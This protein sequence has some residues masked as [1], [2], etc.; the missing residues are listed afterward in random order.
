MDAA[1]ALDGYKAMNADELRTL[2]TKHGQCLTCGRQLFKI[3]RYGAF[4]KKK[5][6]TLEGMVDNGRCLQCDRRPGDAVAAPT[7]QM[8]MLTLSRDAKSV[9]GQGQ[10]KFVQMPSSGN[11]SQKPQP[12]PKS[13]PDEATDSVGTKWM[14]AT[15][16]IQIANQIKR[17]S[18]QMKRFDDD[19]TH[20]EE[21][22]KKSETDSNENVAVA[23]T[24][25]VAA[26]NEP[27][28]LP[29]SPHPQNQPK[30]ER[31]STM[32]QMQSFLWSFETQL[33]V[34]TMLDLHENPTIQIEACKVL[35]DKVRD[36]LDGFI[37]SGATLYV[38]DSIEEHF[39]NE[40][41]IMSAFSLMSFVC[42][43]SDVIRDTFLENDGL[44]M[45][46]NIFVNYPRNEDVLQEGTK[47]LTVLCNDSNRSDL[48]ANYGLL[49]DLIKIS[50]D[51]KYATD[52]R[53]LVSKALS[54]I[55]SHS[56][57]ARAEISLMST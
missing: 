7:K 40:E 12:I 2:R 13:L 17:G 39:S 8:S 44:V 52:T 55:S 34:E 42:Q 45:I 16:K 47:L 56:E 30:A 53:A 10:D 50:K 19:Q 54:V 51:Q 27:S 1:G 43:K 20:H 25:A 29:E 28:E 32:E 57:I 18:D 24:V 3:A 6:I 49:P 46:N 14:K 9:S 37:S 15:T 22:K 21:S 33:V 23:A 48:V 26:S 4:K 36:D 5:P 38:I 41:V 11:L 35:K 31:R